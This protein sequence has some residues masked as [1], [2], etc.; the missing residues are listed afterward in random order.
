MPRIFRDLQNHEEIRDR[1]RKSQ[2]LDISL[3]SE[4][5][6]SELEFTHDASQEILLR[7]LNVIH[8]VFSRQLDDNDGCYYVCDIYVNKLTDGGQNQLD[9]LNYGFRESLDPTEVA[10]YPDRE[11]LH[12]YI[13]GG[14]GIEVIC[15][16]IQISEYI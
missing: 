9:K 6:I 11:L 3:K 14:V 10:Y 1:L 15:E 5:T 7:C 12:L 13:E 4:G 8:I 16:S 2:I